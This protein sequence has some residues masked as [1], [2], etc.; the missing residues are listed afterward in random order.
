LN[1]TSAQF[2]SH[3]THESHEPCFAAT[4]VSSLE[5]SPAFLQHEGLTAAT[6]FFAQCSHETVCFAAEDWRL[7]ETVDEHSSGL[8]ASSVSFFAATKTNSGTLTLLA[9]AQATF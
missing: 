6:D 2:F 3:A 5:E 9:F 8:A 7:C 1:L 4:E